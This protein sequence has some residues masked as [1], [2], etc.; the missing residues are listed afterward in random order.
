MMMAYNPAAQFE[1]K[2]SDVEFRR[3][4]ARTL[5]ARVYQ[6]RGA[7]PFP[8]LLDLHGGAWNDKDRLANAPMDEALAASGILVVA[9]DL[10]LA[11]EA[12]YPASVQDANYGIRWLK[13]KAGEWK[14]D[15]TTLGALGSSSGGHVIELCAM[16]PRDPRYNAHPLPEAPGV[17]ATLAYV[18]TRSPISDPFARFQ[19]AER[20][21]RAEMMQK[22]RTYFKPWETIFEGNPQQMLDRREAVSLPPLLIMQGGL[23]DN[24]LPALQEK[25]AASYRAAGGECQLEVFAGCQHMWVA[26]PGPQTDRAHEMVKAFIARQLRAMRRAA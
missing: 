18:A 25:F 12:P 4:P 22:S 17:D 19:Q 8:T 1:I 9:V 6:P 21:Q 5:M 23:D 16:R 2:V 14:G 20:M 26:E 24:V 11:P 10:T 13:A 7:G 15:P 3:A